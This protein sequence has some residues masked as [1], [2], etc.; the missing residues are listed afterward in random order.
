MYRDPKQLETILNAV[1]ARSDLQEL[2]LK[3]IGCNEAKE[4][5]EAGKVFYF[6]EGNAPDNR[7]WFERMVADIE[8]V[9]GK[10]TTQKTNIKEGPAAFE[11]FVAGEKR[12]GRFRMAD[13]KAACDCDHC[14]A[15]AKALVPRGMT[16]SA[17]LDGSDYLLVEPIAQD[18]SSPIPFRL[19]LDGVMMFVDQLRKKYLEGVKYQTEARLGGKH[20]N[21]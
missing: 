5:A 4:Q 12:P 17:A 1:L 7:Q 15:D 21:A 2:V 8:D 18:G 6:V 16:V 3:Q 11:S 13:K 10:K 20:G 14:K 9:L 19:P